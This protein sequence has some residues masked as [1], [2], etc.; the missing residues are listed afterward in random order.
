[1]FLE[2]LGVLPS[3]DA[4]TLAT[5]CHGP[6]LASARMEIRQG[7]ALALGLTIDGDGDVVLVITIAEDEENAVAV[8]VAPE[9][10]RHFGR[11]LRDMSREADRLQDELEDLDP[12]EVTDRLAAIRNRYEALNDPDSLDGTAG[13]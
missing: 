2:V 8:P 7:Q 10:A 5:C 4:L 11:S 6:K 9:V 1:M 12:E 3:V 13:R